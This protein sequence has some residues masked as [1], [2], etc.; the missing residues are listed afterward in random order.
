MML[1]TV[2]K[3]WFAFFTAYYKTNIFSMFSQKYNENSHHVFQFLHRQQNG[4]AKCISFLVFQ[5]TA[6]KGIPNKPLI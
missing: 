4:G 3:Y 6:A 5:P 1:L 2:T